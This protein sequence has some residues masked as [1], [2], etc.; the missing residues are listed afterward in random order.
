MTVVLGWLDLATKGGSAEEVAKA[1]EVAREHA[2][3]GQVLAR[4]A[5]GGTADSRPTG[6]SAGAVAAFATVSVRPQ[7]EARGVQLVVVQDEGSTA[8]VEGEP[9]LLQILT[10]LLLNALE[11]SPARSVVRLEVSRDA[12]NVCFAV[13][14]EG[15]GVPSQIQPLLFAGGASLRPGGAGIGLAHSR[16]LAL[17]H[18]GDLAWVPT[19]RGA[20]FVVSWPMGRASAT[21]SSLPPSEKAQ[22]EGMRILLI[23]DDE[24]VTTLLELTLEARGAEILPVATLAQLR[25]VLDHRPVIDVVLVDLSPLASNL[26]GALQ[27]IQQV[28]P[29]AA[30]VL[31]SGQPGGVPVSVEKCFQAWVRK[32][33]DTDQL[34]KTLATLSGRI[35]PPRSPGGGATQ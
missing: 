13:Q 2:Y 34:V 28:C 7:S 8:F 35:V 10:N 1:I 22:L 15:P 11:F 24:A 16:H 29:D 18:G 4:R 17:E 12:D 9:A 5:I 30:I 19:T 33:F 3:R 21:H 23:E 31:T 6:R 26:E 20:R 14:D 32:P 27:E 25:T